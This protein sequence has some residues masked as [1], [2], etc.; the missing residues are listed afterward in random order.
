MLRES[1]PLR[2]IITILEALGDGARMNK[3][4][5]FLIDHVRQT[6]SRSICRRL[7][8]HDNKL[9]VITL[10]PKL[11][12]LLTDAIQVTQLGAYPVL[13]PR[14]ARR[15]LDSIAGAVEKAMASGY[16]PVLLCSPRLR[17]PLKR[18]VTRQM[19]LTAVLS[20]NE[21]I[22]EIDIEAVGTVSI[23]ED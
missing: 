23:D 5:D 1:V 13:E 9:Q 15:V 12:Q 10:H 16:S 2:D 22:P 14:L 6:L 18:F 19:P 20:M 11:E 8:N 4:P 7:L 21:I 3:D 17:L